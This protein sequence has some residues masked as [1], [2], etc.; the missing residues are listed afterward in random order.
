MIRTLVSLAGMVLTAA[1]ISLAGQAP[2]Q[3][4][5]SGAV[6]NS[7]T[8]APVPYAAVALLPK[9]GDTQTDATGAFQFSHLQPGNYVVMAGKTGFAAVEGQE[10][11]F[12]ISLTASREKLVL[13]LTPLSVIR[14]RVTD[15]EGEPVEG[16][17]VIAMQSK[18]DFGRRRITV[19]NAVRTNDR[20]EYRVSQLRAG[21][22]LIKISGQASHRG[23]YGDNAPHQEAQESF[24]PVF[25]GGSREA[26]GAALLRVGAGADVRADVPVTSQAGH[27]IRGRIV[28]YTPHRTAAL[29]LSSGDEDLG[30]TAE[31]LEYA[32]GRFEIHGVLDGAYCLRAYQSGDDEELLFAERNI[33]MAGRDLEGVTLTL[34]TAP[35]LKGT[36]R[37]ETAQDGPAPDV[38]IYLEAQD[39]LL[40]MSYEHGHRKSSEIRDGAFEIASV[41]PGK[42]WV[43]FEAGEG[44]YVASARAGNTDLLAG[45]ELVVSAG[46]TPEIEIVLGADGGSVVGAI[47]PDA[48]GS[49][50]LM[51]LLVPESCNRPAHIADANEGG[52][53]FSDVAPGKYRLYAWKSLVDVEYSS[54]AVLC[55]LARGGLPVEVEARREAKVKLQKLSEEPK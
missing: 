16:A 25:F 19:V 44:Q 1:L 55:A 40:A 15:S 46:A 12:E 28:N 10:D 48:A 51:A 6:I 13:S 24:A 27:N 4:S 52:F 17:T 5:L 22:Y 30:Q 8:G 41:L 35:S 11:G 43:T 47:A 39:A 32:T 7:A 38:S 29:R 18:I 54:Q 36:V 31:S 3:L 50:E 14:G 42:Y 21:Q 53:V 23:Y 37:L 20:G 34:G 33:E 26:A 2:G 49:A 45:E 9:G